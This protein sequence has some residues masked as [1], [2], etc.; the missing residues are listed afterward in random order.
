[1]FYT[2][3]LH[4]FY[5]STLFFSSLTWLYIVFISLPTVGSSV[6]ILP[7]MQETQVHSL[8][9]EDPLQKGMATSSFLENPMDREAWWATVQ[10]VTQSQKPK[11][12]SM[13]T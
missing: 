8:G 1:M 3:N 9:Q 6:K 10:R 2:W 7:A 11:Q 4:L 5:H 12:L 13:H